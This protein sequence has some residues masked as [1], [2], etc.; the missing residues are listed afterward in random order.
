MKKNKSMN[1]D[2]ILGAGITGLSS[3]FKTGLDIYESRN[4]PGGICLS[5]YANR[6]G[7]TKKTLNT[8]RFE[9]GGGHWIFGGTPKV[10]RFIRSLVRIKKY[11]RKS[12]VFFPKTNLFVPYPIQNH[13]YY[14]PDRIKRKAL[15]E[16]LNKKSGSEE[17]DTMRDWLLLNFGKTLS[18]HFFFSF[19]EAY[20]AGLYK[21]IAPQDKYKTP[22]NNRLIV[23][24]AREKTPSVGYNSTFDYPVSGLDNLIKKLAAKCNIHYEKEVVHIDINKKKVYF[25]DNTERTYNKVISTIPLN[26]MM[27]LT[28]INAGKQDPYTA[29]LVVNIGA[30]KGI[31]CP[32][33]HW[34]YVPSSESGLHRIGFYSNVDSSFLPD[35]NNRVSI[36]VE[37]AYRSGTNLSSAQKN[38]NVKRILDELTMWR[39]IDKVDVADATWIDTAYTW[40]YPNSIWREKAISMLKQHGIYQIGRYGKWKFQGIAES[41]K[42]GLESEKNI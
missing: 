33:H 14:L 2:I 13:L 16:I 3:G 6:K 36:Y 9:I 25:R 10:S 40:N 30:S 21:K 4:R 42:D 19:H 38:I 22:V 1:R 26:K 17:I 32:S 24:G 28:G 39:F 20:T 18:R 34:L 23:D 8:Y 27:H 15:D 35:R 41:L 5:Y 37:K 12:A 7:I 31:L 11:E 29:V